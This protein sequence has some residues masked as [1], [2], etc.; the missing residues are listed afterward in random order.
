MKLIPTVTAF[1]VLLALPASAKSFSFLGS[2]QSPIGFEDVKVPV[3]GDN[4]LKYCS[5][6][7]DHILQIESVD[8]SPNPPLA[9]VPYHPVL[10][11]SWWL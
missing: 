1:L 7:A 11:S 6:P 5:D 3:G 10:I 2:D 8:L 9:Y 4:P